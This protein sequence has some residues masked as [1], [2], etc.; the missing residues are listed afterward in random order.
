MEILD[1]LKNNKDELIPEDFELF[2]TELVVGNYSDAYKKE[3]LEMIKQMKNWNKTEKVAE[4][5]QKNTVSK[6]KVEIANLTPANKSIANHSFLEQFKADMNAMRLSE[7]YKTKFKAYIKSHAEFDESFVDT[8]FNLFESY[9]L[10]AVISE[11]QM[12]ESFL[13]KYFSVLE[14]EKI[15]RYQL[16]SESFFM[17]HF[18]DFD[19]EVVLKKGK[20]EWRKKE[21]RSKQLDVFLRL[22]GVKA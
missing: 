5:L 21:C 15:A 3:C 9:E 19:A 2:Q 17:K 16:F 10:N 1:I 4:S 22:K 12:S 14:K 11:M 6:A 7:L 13:E 8:N 18:S 20:N